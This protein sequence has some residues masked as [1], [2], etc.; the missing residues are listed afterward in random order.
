MCTCLSLQVVF[1]VAF[2]SPRG[3]HVA[4]DDISFSPEFCSAETGGLQ[5]ITVILHSV[6]YIRPK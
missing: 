6:E 1:E 5:T 3:G 4:V 2:N